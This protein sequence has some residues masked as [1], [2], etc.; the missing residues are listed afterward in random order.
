MS[1][2]FTNLLKP[3]ETFFRSQGILITIFVLMMGWAPGSPFPAART[4]LW[5]TDIRNVATIIQASSMIQELQDLVLA[6]VFSNFPFVVKFIS[7]SFGSRG[8]RTLRLTYS[9]RLKIFMILPYMMMYFCQLEGLTINRFACD[10][11]TRLPRF[12]SR[13]LQPKSEAVD[14]FFQNW[15]SEN[16][17]LVP[18][19]HGYW[20]SAD[21]H[22]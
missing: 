2:I 6:E 19:P 10:Y 8:I 3:F 22:A 20:K 21:T 13:F 18:P 14:A 9:V 11:N 12:N 1:F 4:V 7:M 16:N 17:W 5:N 15:S